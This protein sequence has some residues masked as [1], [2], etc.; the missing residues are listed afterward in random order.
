MGL[1]RLVSWRPSRSVRMPE[2]CE[3]RAGLPQDSEL[4]LGCSD[5]MGGCVALPGDAYPTP[6]KSLLWHCHEAHLFRSALPDGPAWRTEASQGLLLLS[7]LVF[8]CVARVTF[9][10]Y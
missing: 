2:P 8:C 5:S 3:G 9:W 1:P 6:T 4:G 7:C 10:P